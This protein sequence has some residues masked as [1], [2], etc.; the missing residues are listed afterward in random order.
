MI[1]HYIN[2]IV[3]FYKRQENVKILTVNSNIIIFG[4][5][6]SQKM[7]LL[8]NFLTRNVSFH[9]SFSFFLNFEKF[10][11]LKLLIYFIKYLFLRII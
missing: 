10:N 1:C 8:V 7:S 4:K 11:Y 3:K 5:K 2:N 9:L 6:N